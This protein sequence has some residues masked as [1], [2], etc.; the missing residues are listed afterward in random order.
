LFLGVH[1]V[2]LYAQPRTVS[3]SWITGSG[4]LDDELV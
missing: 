3:H 4:S 2:F 1:A